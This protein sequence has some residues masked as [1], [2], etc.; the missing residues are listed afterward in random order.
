[1]K[2]PT[3]SPRAASPSSRSKVKPKQ[4]PIELTDDI[5]GRIALKAYELFE[6]RGHGG[7]EMEDWLEAEQIVM[8]E[9]R[10]AGS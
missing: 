3:R 2:K 6:Q 10:Q 7:R 5:R 4:K 8:A 1:M 9:I